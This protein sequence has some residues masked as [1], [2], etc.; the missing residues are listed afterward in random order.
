L[1][2]FSDELHSSTAL[3]E[4]IFERSRFSAQESER[5]AGKMQRTTNQNWGRITPR[6]VPGIGERRSGRN[7]KQWKPV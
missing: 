3:L 6:F 5:F 7:R 4:A 1:L 2:F